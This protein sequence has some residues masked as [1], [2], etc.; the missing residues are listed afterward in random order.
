MRREKKESNS[1]KINL[2]NNLRNKNKLKNQQINLN[3]MEC[4]VLDM[5]ID[6][7]IIKS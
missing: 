2:K 7:F 1:I 4:L 3:E 6:N 5:Y